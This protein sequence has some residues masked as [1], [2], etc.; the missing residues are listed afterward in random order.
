LT[1]RQL[2]DHVHQRTRATAMAQVPR[3]TFCVGLRDPKKRTA[4]GQYLATT[5]RRFSGGLISAF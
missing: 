3:D 1:D 2:I 5:R 4:D